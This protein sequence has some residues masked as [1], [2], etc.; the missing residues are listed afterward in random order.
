MFTKHSVR[1]LTQFLLRKIL[2][3]HNN[4]K[5]GAHLR[6]NDS[7][8]NVLKQTDELGL[9]VVQFFVSKAIEKK[10]N[11][12]SPSSA[13]KEFL[14]QIMSKNNTQVFIHASY[15]IN[16]ASGRDLA[17][18]ASKSLLRK[19]ISIAKALGVK[20]IVLHPGTANGFSPD[21][22]LEEIKKLGIQRIAA[23]LNEVLKNETTVTILLENTA[24]GR[25]AI[26]SDLEDFAQIRKLLEDPEKVF[27]CLDTAHAHAYGYDVS[28]L[29]S[30][31]KIVENLL[32]IDLI[33]LIHLNDIDG[34]QGA[35]QDKH[36]LPGEGK[37]GLDL[38]HKIAHFSALSH[39]PKVIELP[40]SSSEIIQSALISLR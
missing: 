20:H 37:L 27:F 35:K 25:N 19:E 10:T 3:S 36:T 34:E 6:I 17:Y 32:G 11:Y 2:I 30:F 21:L 28:N 16:A 29:E 24:H 5:I 40:T 8:M 22:P 12:L 15:W 18:N 13:E 38:L 31:F 23:L 7:F 9:D 33:K 39:I 14:Q 26:G 1:I 4:T